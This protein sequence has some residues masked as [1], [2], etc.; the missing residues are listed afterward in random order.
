MSYIMA[1]GNPRVMISSLDIGSFHNIL[2]SIKK[3]EELN[4]ILHSPGGDGT[5]IE[6]MIEMCRDHL[7]MKGGKLRVIVP[8]IAKSAAT[9]FA[10]G[11]DSIIMSYSSELGPI[12]PQVLVS[13]GGVASYVSASAYVRAR[14]T[15][16]EDI[17][18][19]QAS[20]GSTTA[21][22]TQLASLNVPFVF[23]MDSQIQF[24]EN[25]A[26]R[27]LSKYMFKDKYKSDAEREKKARELAGMLLSK[28]T[29]P[30]HAHFISAK[31]ARAMGLS[32]EVIDRTDN[33]WKMIWEYYMRAEM[34]MNIPLQPGTAKVKLF[35]SATASLV[36]Q[37]TVRE[38]R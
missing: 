25:T 30:S 34:Q 4:V 31:T 13:N 33:L 21:L 7:P 14:D 16:T 35:E 37:E 12:D 9:V 24:A 10:L 32:V 17:A 5:V 3:A 8:N 1:F 19:A 38:Q 22:L 20:G 28:A 15:L 2:S 36:T 23:E 11:A 27:L 29:F 18:K 26:T 6:K